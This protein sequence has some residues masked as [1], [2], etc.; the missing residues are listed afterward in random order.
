[1]RSGSRVLA[2]NQQASDSRR[3]CSQETEWGGHKSWSMGSV[4]EMGAAGNGKG[5]C[6][7]NPRVKTTFSPLRLVMLDLEGLTLSRGGRVMA[8]LG[9][10]ESQVRGREKAARYTQ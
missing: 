7:V 8:D 9:L 4:P 6:L 1:M 5:P 10:E 3:S 2:T